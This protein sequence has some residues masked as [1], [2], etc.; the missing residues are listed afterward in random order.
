LDR[1]E[2][3]LEVIESNPGIR[4]NEIMRI[5]DIR[6]GT[7]SHYIKKLDDEGLIKVSTTPRI[8]RM[9]PIGISPEE[10][11]ICKILSKDTPRKIIL[12]TLEKEVVTSKEV[13]EF[14]K[15]SS[16]VVSVNLN[17]LFEEGIIEKRYDIPSNKY[18]LRNKD[19]IKG[20]LREYYP[21]M[22]EK[23]S[24]NLIEMLGIRV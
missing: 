9:Y 16:S 23:L 21:T 20:I 11:K 14:V 10:E 3:V 7:L 24:E 4:F 12:F 1:R 6:N 19:M 8:T 2:I 13:K 5:T 22:R 15:K 17:E 18:S